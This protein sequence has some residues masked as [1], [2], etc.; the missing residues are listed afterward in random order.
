MRIIRKKLKNLSYVYLQWHSNSMTKLST[1]LNF[2]YFQT[3][4]L[5]LISMI[6]SLQLFLIIIYIIK[7][8]ILT[9][10]KITISKEEWIEQT[11]LKQTKE[12]SIKLKIR[13]HYLI[14]F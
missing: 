6:L 5:I 11:H 1:I 14:V 8:K 4:L 3:H 9:E 7:N 10:M 13:S 12:H 2:N